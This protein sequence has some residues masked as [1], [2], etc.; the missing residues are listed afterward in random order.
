[1]PKKSCRDYPAIVADQNIARLKIVNDIKKAAMLEPPP[2][3]GENHE[4][5]MISRFGGAL[6]YKFC[7]Q[8]IIKF[9]GLHRC[10]S[11]STKPNIRLSAALA[12]I[13]VI[14]GK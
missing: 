12:R 1:M 14:I 13:Q 4:P 8:D 6:G 11:Q 3:P 10:I 9:G 7:R 2:L 5:R